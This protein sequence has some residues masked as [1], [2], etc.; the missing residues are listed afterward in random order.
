VDGVPLSMLLPSVSF[1]EWKVAVMGVL[2]FVA[3]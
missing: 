3:T 2:I 1:D